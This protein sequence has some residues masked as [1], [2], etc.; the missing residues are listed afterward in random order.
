MLAVQKYLLTHSLQQLEVEHGVN[1]RFSAD[2]TKFSLNYDQITAKSDDPIA[3]QCRGLVLR[4]R[5]TEHIRTSIVK[6]E[7]VVGPTDVVARPMDRFFN[8][9][10]VHAADIN[11]NSARV[12]CKIDGTMCLLY[13][14]SVKDQWCVATRS[15]PEADVCF[16]DVPSPLKNNT[17]YELFMYAAEKTLL[18]EALHDS[19]EVE[20]PIY[21]TMLEAWAAEPSM[22]DKWLSVLDKSFTYIFELTTP[23]NRVVVKY[24][25]YRTTL[26]CAR[27]T[28]TGVYMHHTRL[29][30]VGMPVVEEWP[31][32]TLQDI[33]DFLLH[34]D[35]AQV[36]GAVVIDSQN[37]R[38]KVKSKQWVLASRA[39]D[40]VTMSKRN[41]L[42][43]I[44]NGQIDDIL[45]LLDSHVA[46]YLRMLQA[47]TMEY[48]M[49]LDALFEQFRQQPDRKSF[50]LA[51]QASGEWQTPFFN[52]YSKKYL[53][54]IDWLMELSKAN[55]L[56]DSLLDSILVVVDNDCFGV[57]VEP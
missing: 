26:L 9:G 6:P 37:N 12:Q 21:G 47:N 1:H 11:W 18:N 20:G 14:D 24:D 43:A 32:K 41:A 49:K 31:L 56:T 35:P 36:E 39:K 17:F 3:N 8:A 7:E 40:S 23:I 48:C 55:K 52:L 53:N 45:P 29:H 54:T 25:N 50:A 57:I 19:E 27:E 22:L 30:E 33:E 5:I 2:G 28:A 4:P 34:S 46:D 16:G 42:E 10:D 51:V 15:V 13:W 44:I 38:V